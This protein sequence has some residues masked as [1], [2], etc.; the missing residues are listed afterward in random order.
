MKISSQVY[1]F[2]GFNYNSQIFNEAMI[3][4]ENKVN[5]SKSLC[6]H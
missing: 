6:M 3:E 5:K 1:I 2:K 4:K